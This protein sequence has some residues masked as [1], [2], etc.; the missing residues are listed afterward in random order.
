MWTFRDGGFTLRRI[1]ET[2]DCVFQ[3]DGRRHFFTRGQVCSDGRLKLALNAYRRRITK[4]SSRVGHRQVEKC[5]DPWAGFGDFVR[6]VSEQAR[7]PHSAFAAE[8]YDALEAYLAVRTDEPLCTYGAVEGHRLPFAVA[9]AMYYTIYK[10]C[11]GAAFRDR[12]RI[13]HQPTDREC[14]LLW[15]ALHPD[16]SSAMRIR[17]LGSSAKFWEQAFDNFRAQNPKK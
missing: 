2:G 6:A 9:I 5:S 4:S 11:A 8:T 7:D 10:G 1:T 12:F 13:K 14:K 16:S 3:K 15:G 17:Q